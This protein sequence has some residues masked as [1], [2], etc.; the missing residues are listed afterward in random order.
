M[1]GQLIR[2]KNAKLITALLSTFPLTYSVSQNNNH[3][4]SQECQNDSSESEMP[5][6]L[7]VM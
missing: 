6:Y 3:V 5:D 4:A 2:S 1:H 7:L